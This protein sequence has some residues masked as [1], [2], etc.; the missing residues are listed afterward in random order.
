MRDHASKILSMVKNYVSVLNNFL[1]TKNKYMKIV[2]VCIVYFM[3][4]DR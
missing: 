1:N 2:L 3:S 4:N